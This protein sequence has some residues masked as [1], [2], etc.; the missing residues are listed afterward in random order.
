MFKK[1]IDKNAASEQKIR[2]ELNFLTEKELL[3]EI[4]IEL[5]KIKNKSDDIARKIVIW[6]D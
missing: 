1:L 6:S 3:I 2:E 5:K 4:L